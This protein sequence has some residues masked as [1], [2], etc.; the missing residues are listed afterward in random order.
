MTIDFPSALVRLPEGAKEGDI[1][2]SGHKVAAQLSPSF[3]VRELFL[4]KEGKRDGEYLLLYPNKA[5][6]QRCF[7]E[8]GLLHGPSEFFDD[9]GNLLASAAFVLGRRQGKSY[10]YWTNGTMRSLEEFVEGIAEGEHIAYFP[11]GQMKSKLFY[12]DG[13]LA[14]DALF[15]HENGE[16]KRKESY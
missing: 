1:L 11:S 5:V 13:L 4:V 14:G 2:P 9:E 8:K 10:S 15:F 12:K 3:E 7:Y 6:A 16:L